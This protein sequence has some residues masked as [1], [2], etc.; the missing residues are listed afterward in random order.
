MVLFVSTLGDDHQLSPS[1]LHL[2][3]APS[4]LAFRLLSESHR[5]HR[6]RRGCLI[7]RSLAVSSV[8]LRI[9]RQF[10]PPPHR[11]CGPM[12]QSLR[13][14]LSSAFLA[15]PK[16]IK[17]WVQ[18]TL[19]FAGDRATLFYRRSPCSRAIHATTISMAPTSL[20][21]PA[22]PSVMHQGAPAHRRYVT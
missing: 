1:V 6:I 16:Q 17:P 18:Q 5:S 19:R 2:R 11:S 22:T 15:T 8:M 9:T 4:T 12:S 21:S 7:F 14:S 13:T 20:R 3:L 10:D